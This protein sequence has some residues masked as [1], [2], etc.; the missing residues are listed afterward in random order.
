MKFTQILWEL[1]DSKKC[2]LK[3]A[4]YIMAKSSNQ[5]NKAITLAATNLYTA[6]YNGSSFSNALKVCPF[7]E[8][9]KDYISFI[10]FAERSGKLEKT[11]GFLKDKLE[12]DEQNLEKIKEAS[13]YPAFVIVLAIAVGITL[14]LYSASLLSWGNENPQMMQQLYSS[15]ILS[16]SFLFLFCLIAFA[17]I[18]KTLGTNKLYEAFLATGFLVKAGESLSNAVNN[19]VN[20]LGYD[21]K[22]GQLFASAGEKLSYGISVKNAFSLN[23]KGM[24]QSMEIE[25][26]FFYA[27]NSG[28]ENELFE[29]IALSL[30]ARDEK[31]RTICFKL[32]EPFFLTGTGIFLLVFLMN[33]VLPLLTDS[34]LFI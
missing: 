3:N 11:L 14:Y 5:K 6:L 20:I 7:V 25:E 9:G 16:F 18:K 23:A 10:S 31:R 27:E 8:F 34:T 28:G 13:I 29:K 19:A 1:V 26:A 15:L 2:G 12:R 30:N 4:L 32:I 21:S 24:G 22:E 17:V 33:S